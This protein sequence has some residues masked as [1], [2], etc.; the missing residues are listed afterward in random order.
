MIKKLEERE[1]AIKMIDHWT[2]DEYELIYEI[3]QRIQE[4]KAKLKEME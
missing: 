4:L 2:S 1:F 3:R